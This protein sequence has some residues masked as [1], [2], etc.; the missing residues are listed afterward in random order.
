MPSENSPHR[1][2]VRSIAE[3]LILVVFTPAVALTLW[4]V[5]SRSEIAR[6]RLEY[7]RIA[8]AILAQ[9]DSPES[10]RPM[11]EWAVALL[12]DSAPVK[13]S[14]TQA[15]SLVNGSSTLTVTEWTGSAYGT[16]YYD[17]TRKKKVG[18]PSPTP[19]YR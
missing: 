16:Y 6:L 14:F 2:D 11:R 12:N 5:T 1:R 7:V 4:Y 9:V 10:Q 18:S 3:F 15:E 17:D 13:L 8:T 19:N